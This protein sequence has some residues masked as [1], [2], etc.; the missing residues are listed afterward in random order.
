MRH[1]TTRTDRIAGS[2]FVVRTMPGGPIR[3][4]GLARPEAAQRRKILGGLIHE[5]H[6]RA[7]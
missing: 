7:A 3:G 6:A 5:Y 4:P 1:I 2:I